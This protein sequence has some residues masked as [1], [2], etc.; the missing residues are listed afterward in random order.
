MDG[1]TDGTQPS[2]DTSVVVRIIGYVINYVSNS[3]PF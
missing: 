3:M 1:S 2:F